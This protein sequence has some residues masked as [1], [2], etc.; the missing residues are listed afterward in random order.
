MSPATG[1]FTGFG[2]VKVFRP[3]RDVRFSQDKTPCKTNVSIAGGRDGAG[4]YYFSVSP[5]G[6][7]L[8]GGL[9]Q[10]SK[11]QLH[12]FRQL[13]DDERRTGEMD[14]LLA[15][16]DGQGF[17]MMEEGALKTAPRGW[18]KDHPRVDVLRRKHL[19][20]GQDR[21]PGPWLESAACLEQVAAAWRSVGRWNAWLERRVGVPLVEE[22]PGLDQE[23][24]DEP[25]EALEALRGVRLARGA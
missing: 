21:E 24:M 25:R 17:A 12:R 13:Q 5:D 20:V 1:G 4:T 8:G 11:D 15:E 18:S 7:D 19:A 22:T 9:Y 6:V 2:P 23:L 10:P 3:R 14:A 16:L